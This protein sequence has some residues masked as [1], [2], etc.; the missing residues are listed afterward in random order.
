MS[1]RPSRLQVVPP[2]PTG[3]RRVIDLTLDEVV[4]AVAAAV[5]ARLR[6]GSDNG[7]RAPAEVSTKEMAAMLRKHTSTLQ[8]WTKLPGCPAFRSGERLWA[9]PVEETRAWMREYF[10]G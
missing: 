8:R 9:W 5:C 6:E 10:N 3:Q 4:E 7:L 1:G 2:R